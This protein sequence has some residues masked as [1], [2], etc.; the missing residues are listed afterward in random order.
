MSFF[1]TLAE[2]AVRAQLDTLDRGRLTVVDGDHTSVHGASDGLSATV[3]VLDRSFYRAVAFGGHVGAA[4][5]Y[6]D[7]AW[8]TPDL[9]AL[10]RLFV[11]NREVLDG[12]ETGLARVAQPLRQ[13]LHARNRNTESGS[14]R[15]IHAHYDLGNDFFREFLDETMTYSAGI[16]DDPDSTLKDA[17]VSKYDRLCR[18]LD[19]GPDDAIITVATDGAA[20]YPSERA[21]TLAHRFGGDIDATD[22]AAIAGEHLHHLSTEHMIDCTEADRRRIFNLGYYTWVEQQGTPFEL[23]EQR[24]QQSF[25]Q[26][27]RRYVDVWDAMIDDFNARVAAG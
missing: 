27:L 19:L 5:A 23:F 3:T 8:T 4:E 16:F 26:G 24:R 12:M 14:R 6:A 15:N 18:K 1:D 17:S 10:V 21:K 11:R 13:F 7:G 22:A 9:T 20:L 2:K 25:W